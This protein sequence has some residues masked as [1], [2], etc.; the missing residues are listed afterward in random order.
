MTPINIFL[1]YAHEDSKLV[2]ELEKQLQ[3]LRNL[4]LIAIWDDREISPGREWEQEID[5]HL[6]DSHVILLLISPDF[7]ST[8]YCN[9]K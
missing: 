6:D 1:C 8:D 4:G 2:E 7:M 3:P 5:R 9:K